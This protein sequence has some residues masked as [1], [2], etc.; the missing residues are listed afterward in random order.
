MPIPHLSKKVRSPHTWQKNRL[1]E[2]KRTKR[3][4][5]K[6][7]KKAK[8]FFDVRK[9]KHGKDK[10]GTALSLGVILA[11]PF[12]LIKRFWRFLLFLTLLGIII[13]IGLFAWYSNEL[14][15]PN[16]L[17]ERAIAQS[18]KIYDRTGEH[19]LYEI[20][21]EEQRT[22]ITLAEIP[23]YAIQATLSLEDKHFYEHSGISLWGIFRGLVVAKLQG[24]RFQGGSTLTQQLVKNAI[25]TDERT[26]ER[27]IKEIILAYQ[28]EK[29]YSKEEILQMYFNEIPYGSTAYGIEAASHL[30]FGKSA[31]DLSLAEA[32][33]LAAMPQKPSYFSPYGSHL[34]ELFGRQQYCLDQ[35]VKLGYIAEDKAAA[36]KDEEINFKTKVEGIEAPHFVFFVKELL[37]EKYGEKLVEQGGLKIIS[38]LDYDLQKKAE[39]IITEQTEKNLANYN[40]SNAALVAIDIDTGQIITMVGSKDFFNEEIDGQVNVAL[41]N[42]QPGSSFKPVVYTAGFER[43]LVPETVVYDLE[44][45]FPVFDGNYTPH[46]YDLKERGPVN[47]RTALAGS[48]N[49]PAVKMIYLAGIANV[50]DLADELGYT[51]LKDRSRF[52]L[53]LVLGGGEVKLLEHTNAYAA[54]AREGRVMKYTPILKIEGQN[55]KV[56]EEY[57]EQPTNKVIEPNIARMVTNI[58]SDNEARAFI[59]GASNYLTIGDRPVAAKTGTTNDYRDAWTLGYTPQVAV[60][61][62]VGNNDNSEMKR[63]AAGG[64]VAAPIWNKFIK[65]AVADLPAESFKS[66]S[67]DIPDK[68]MLGGNASGVKVKIDKMSGL[69][70]TEY[71]PQHLV[72]E[73]TFQQVHSILHYV[74]I[75]DPLGPIPE[76]PENN[77]YYSYWEEA[78][79][80]WAQEQGLVNQSPP[81]EYDN[82]HLAEDQPS[83][84]ITSPQN[85][86]TITDNSYAVQLEIAVKKTFKKLEF[87]LDNTVF[88]INYLDDSNQEITFP[89]TIINGPH[90]LTVKVYDEVENVAQNAVEINLN[91]TAYLN[92]SWLNPSSPATLTPVDFP[93]ILTLNIDDL[94]KVKK[95]DYYFRL[96]QDANPHWLGY[97]EY[98]PDNNI[99]FTWQDYPASGVYKVYPIITNSQNQIIKGPEITINVE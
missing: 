19:L 4:I 26:I 43:G 30:Y 34:D 12:K 44:T 60:G 27:K 51:T 53:S 95:I 47:L 29:K 35:M 54:L 63:G 18:T 93:Y 64:T 10:K 61:V 62:W 1:R 84:K 48:L 66:P 42:R 16:K 76:H 40:A 9:S 57:K 70:A 67:Y 45:V 7:R 33:I 20:H 80:K 32:A 71:T 91:R 72:E 94:T 15:D 49:I 86:Q 89:L 99:D 24:K 79:N 59:F 52:G 36:A 31:K 46:D 39:E 81:T 17:T 78:V 55:G 23:P 2:L 77:E 96:D 83:V 50:L 98:F 68:P 74:D 11:I 97:V 90:L 82:I 87:Y 38:T 56:M 22:L 21:G 37:S 13:L 5:D 88:A 3:K 85:N 6:R 58:L 75:N 92:I 25:L 65:E 8:R 69:L 14:P 73:K 41:A 28:I